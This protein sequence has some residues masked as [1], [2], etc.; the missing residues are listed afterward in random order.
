MDFAVTLFE[1]T[2]KGEYFQLS[3]I[4]QRASFAKDR[5]HRNLMTSG[6]RTQLDFS[7][8]ILT[9][10]QLQ[11]GSRLVVVVSIIKQPAEQINYG[12]GG[13]V[14]DETAKDALLPL[15]IKWYGDSYI[16]IPTA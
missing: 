3:Y 12:T 5:S 9:S 8:G 16:E 4:W 14:S 15:E 10:R 7:A 6:E 11:P 2:P 13:A 1:L